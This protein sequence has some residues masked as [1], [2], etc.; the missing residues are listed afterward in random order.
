MHRLIFF[1]TLLFLGNSW[2]Y[3]QASFLINPITGQVLHSYR[4]DCP[5][6]PASLTKIMTAYVIFDAIERGEIHM[7]DTVIVPPEAT[8]VEPVKIGL[9]AGE[10][11]LVKD[12]IVAII[13]KSANDAAVT[14]AHALAPNEAAFAK[15]MTA[16]A[17]E[18]GLKN[19]KFFNASGLPHPHQIT[20][21]RDMATLSH[22]LQTVHKKYYPIFSQQSFVYKGKVF[23]TSNPFLALNDGVDGIKTGYVHA[24]KFNF[25]VS[26]FKNGRR[27]IAVVLGEK[28]IPERNKKIAILLNQN[29]PGKK[30]LHV[31]SRT[32]ETRKVKL[33]EKGH[34]WLVQIGS[35][36]SWKHASLHAR[37]VC[38]KCKTRLGKGPRYSIVQDKTKKQ[39]KPSFGPFHSK[40]SAQALCKV[41]KEKGIDCMLIEQ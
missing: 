24:S 38:K 32:Q 6:P 23:K 31:I 9:K 25:V 13:V 30:P 5:H 3:E 40:S 14:M 39:Y 29:I 12:L 7:F 16:K 36:S 33:H 22:S 18:L 1:F 34:R 15:M 2:G 35:F 41:F 19:T 26:S 17:Q 11:M 8:K 20:T 10:R 37:T 4:A 21:A 28:T 27:L